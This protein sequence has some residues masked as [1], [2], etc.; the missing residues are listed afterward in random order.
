MINRRKLRIPMLL[1]LLLAG[2]TAACGAQN[3]GAEVELITLERQPCFGFCPVYTLSIHGDGRVEYNG[4]D[5]VEVP[6]P[7]TST[8]DP[9]A[10]QT[11][12]DGMTEAGY[13]DF[14]D[15]YLNQDVT[16]NAYVIT[17]ITLSDGTTKRIEHYLGDF[18]APEV[19]TELEAR[20]D[21]TANSAQW[22]GEPQP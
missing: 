15:A 20:I 16:D 13:F 18:S 14:E 8:I 6:G 11:L 10:V 9:A 12:G 17:S 21:Q 2:I 7:Q 1:I 4:T 22:V 3:E 19:L 5:N